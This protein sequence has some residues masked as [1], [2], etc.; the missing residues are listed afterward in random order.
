[1][2]HEVLTRTPFERLQKVLDN[3][4]ETSYNVHMTTTTP[5]GVQTT[6]QKAR[7]AANGRH[8]IK[9][10]DDHV[11]SVWRYP[12]Q[13]DAQAAVQM[14]DEQLAKFNSQYTRVGK[15]PPARPWR[16]EIV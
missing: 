14:H 5:K 13:A 15:E 9:H 11:S 16:M 1:M 3:P 8:L 4:V 6:E 2:L 12:S 7:A 10:Y